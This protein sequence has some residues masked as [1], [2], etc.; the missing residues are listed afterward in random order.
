VSSP[1]ARR[2]PAGLASRLRW[3]LADGW[4]LVRRELWHLRN[5]PGQLASALIFPVALV[6]LFGYVFAARS[7]CLAV[8]LPADRQRRP[9]AGPPLQ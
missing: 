5:Q 9:A 7:Q 4:I 2:A 1:A 6:V 3:T 8:A